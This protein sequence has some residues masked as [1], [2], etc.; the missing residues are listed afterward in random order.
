MCLSM[1][2]CAQINTWN[3]FDCG[4]EFGGY[5][6]SGIGREHGDEVLHHY[7]QVLSSPSNI[8]PDTLAYPTSICVHTIQ[9]LELEKLWRLCVNC[10]IIGSDYLNRA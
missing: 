8:Q 4:V 10:L 3:V 1:L 9:M 5:K 2:M 6:L 7:T